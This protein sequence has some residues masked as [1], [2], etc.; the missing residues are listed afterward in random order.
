MT[1]QQGKITILVVDDDA[2]ILTILKDNL[3]LDGYVVQTASSGAD[4]IRNAEKDGID[5]IILDLKLPDLDGIQVCRAI[6]THSAVP[7]IMLTARDGVSDKVL[8]LESGADDYIVKPFDYLE[9]AAR[10]NA[11]LRRRNVFQPITAPLKAGDL[12]L[13]PANRDVLMN[14]TKLDLT[15]KEFDILNLLFQYA[16]NVVDRETIRKSL[17]PNQSIYKWSRTIDVH[18]QHLRAKLEANPENPLYIVTVQ[19]VGYK[20]N[21]PD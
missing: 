14:G 9:L 3:E 7:I 4:A 18:I 17:W 10:I 19:G 16:G 11:R 21:C 20:L 6:R 15:K 8:G 5:L 12:V 1:A 2:D 13:N